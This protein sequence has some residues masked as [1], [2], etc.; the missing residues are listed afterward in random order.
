MFTLVSLTGFRFRI[1]GGNESGESILVCLFS[2]C[3]LIL[4][5]IY[6]ESRVYSVSMY[7]EGSGSYILHSLFFICPNL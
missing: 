5:C 2:R 7:S 1:Q 6:S 4:I 3:T